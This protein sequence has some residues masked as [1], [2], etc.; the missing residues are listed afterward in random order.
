MDIEKYDLLNLMK[1]NIDPEKSYTF[2]QGN[3]GSWR[4]EFTEVNKLNFKEK[5]GDFLIELGFE[6]NKN[7]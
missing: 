6:D 3:A 7:W 5:A 4:E 2:R 1:N